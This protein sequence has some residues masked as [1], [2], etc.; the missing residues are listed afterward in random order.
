MKTDA[1]HKQ[2]KENSIILHILRHYFYR[3]KDRDTVEIM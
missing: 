2:Q 1:L 3:N